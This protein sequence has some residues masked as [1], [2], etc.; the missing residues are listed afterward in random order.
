MMKMGTKLAFV[1]ALVVVSGAQA[2][3]NVIGV[4][5]DLSGGTPGQTFDD[6]ISILDEPGNNDHKFGATD[7]FDSVNFPNLGFEVEVSSG[8]S[9]LEGFDWQVTMD[10]NDFSI[11]D[12]DPGTVVYRLE[13]IKQIGTDRPISEVALRGGFDA[14]MPGD[15]LLDDGNIMIEGSIADLIAGDDI[16]TIHWAQVPEPATLGLLAIGGLTLLRRRRR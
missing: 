14:V 11:I 4:F 10:F 15:V 16:I 9:A 13:G 8:P 12:F 6:S 1:A 3:P 7:T 2:D 5:A